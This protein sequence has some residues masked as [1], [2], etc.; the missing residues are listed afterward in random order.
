MYEKFNAVESEAA[1]DRGM[2]AAAH[3]RKWLLKKAREIAVECCNKF[4][5]VVVHRLIKRKICTPDELGPAA[6]SIFRCNDFEW[7]GK[8]RKSKRVSNHAHRILLWK[9]RD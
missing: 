9:L 6:G 4:G 7:T 5:H 2:L 3:K 8:S 1:R